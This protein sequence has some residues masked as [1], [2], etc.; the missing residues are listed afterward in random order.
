MANT[1]QCDAREKEAKEDSD[2]SHV[3]APVFVPS[4]GRDKFVSNDVKHSTTETTLADF[5]LRKM[6]GEGLMGRVFLAEHNT[7]KKL[8]AL[9]SMD[10]DKVFWHKQEEN[11]KSK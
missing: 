1:S 8:Y 11:I 9:K 2:D 7:T 3:K 4:E 5:T 10:K 6:I